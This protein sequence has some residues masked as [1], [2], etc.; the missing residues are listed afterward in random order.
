MYEKRTCN[1]AR[2]VENRGIRGWGHEAGDLMTSALQRAEE[3]RCF[4]GPPRHGAFAEQSF[5]KGSQMVE[6]GLVDF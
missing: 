5:H 4:L 2:R 3:E 6:Y 1:E